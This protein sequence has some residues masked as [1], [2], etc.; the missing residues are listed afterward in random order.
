MAK[1][2][3]T[4]SIALSPRSLSRLGMFVDCVA[5]ATGESVETVRRKVRSYDGLRELARMTGDG[6]KDKLAALVVVGQ[7]QVDAAK[8]TRAAGTKRRIVGKAPA[9]VRVASEADARIL[10]ARIANENSR[11]MVSIDDGVRAQL[12]RFRF[13]EAGR[14]H[15][16]RLTRRK[17]VWSKDPHENEKIAA[18]WNAAVAEMRPTEVEGGPEHGFVAAVVWPERVAAV[19]VSADPFKIGIISD[20]GVRADAA[21]LATCIAD[22]RLRSWGGDGPFSFASGVAVGAFT[23][24]LA[25]VLPPARSPFHRR[26]ALERRRLDLALCA[27]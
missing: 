9:A 10:L 27:T 12:E 4:A 26:R 15:S 19:L 7:Q 21:D 3:L 25:G 24:H 16:F 22:D 1:Q 11:A 20:G 14:A 2:D 13:S 18:A 6:D 23:K 17:T 8:L 5:Q